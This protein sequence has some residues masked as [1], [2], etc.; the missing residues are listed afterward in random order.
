MGN[1]SN[2][3]A[4]KLASFL[5]PISTKIASNKYVKI[6]M[7]S[8]FNCIPFIITG[9]FCLILSKPFM[10]PGQFEDGTFWF[11]F[12]TAWTNFC[13]SYLMPLR[14]VNTLTL[15]S[16]ALIVA[17][18]MG[19]NY[20]KDNETPMAQTILVAS[21]SFLLINTTFTETGITTTFFGGMG[22]FSGMLAVFMGC[23]IFDKLSKNGISFLSLP[24]SVPANLQQSFNSIIPLFITMVCMAVF[25]GVFEIGFGKPFPELIMGVMS[26]VQSG[27]DNIFV[28]VGYYTLGVLTWWTGIHED[29]ILSV[30]DPV[31]FGNL[32]ANA[33]AYA[34]GIDLPYT[35]SF[36]MKAFV[37]IG[38]SG[39]T[40][41][42]VICLLRAKSKELRTL[43]KVSIVPAMFGINEPVI[44]GLPIM[45]NPLFL[46]P[47]ILTTATSAAISYSC[48]YFG[49]V[50]TPA[51]HLGGTSPEII[52]QFFATMDPRAILLWA[53]LI[54][55][56]IT[57]WKPFVNIYDREKLKIE[58]EL[59]A[60]EDTMEM[61]HS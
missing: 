11:D 12:F 44:F 29:A 33:D 38:G 8:F 28:C 6:I 23:I 61:N 34:A 50:N 39:G 17:V 4:D 54:L 46:I 42:L 24:D 15:G 1:I 41:G 32:S 57:I 52:K 49:L 2:R 43:G 55:V 30:F 3:I 58:N 48:F 9:A 25:R 36:A 59:I 45:L 5:M 47:F 18:A 19:Y 27:F 20:A 26:F 13:D 21:T 31:L 60:I 56:Q 37:C 35:F 14:A 22:L 16:L 7:E 10:G 51:F 53:F 40:L